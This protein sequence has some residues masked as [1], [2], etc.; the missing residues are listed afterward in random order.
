MVIDVLLLIIG[1]SALIIATITDIKTREVPDWLNFSLIPAGVGL[2]L[3]H[4]LIFNDWMYFFYGII[5]LAVFVGLAYLFYYARQWGG[6]DSKLLMGIGVLFATYPR[7][8]LNYFNP[9]LNWYFLLIFL[10]N[11]LLIGAIYAIIWSSY[12]AV[13]NWEKFKATYKKYFSSL[14]IFRRIILFIAAVLIIASFA[15]AQIEIKIILLGLALVM[16]LSFHLMVFAKVVESCCMFKNIPVKK[17]TEG[18]WVVK[19]VKIKGKY[20]CGPKDYGLTKEQISKLR[21]SRIKNVVIK[22]GIPFVP[23][24]LV[25]MIISLVWG[26]FIYLLI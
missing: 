15:N 6:G 12:L 25:A 22:E 18:D 21:K 10:F 16:F 17:L 11:L 19:E 26:N 4:A 9:V 20:I 24:F 8:L 7:F 23:S 2:R 5:G 3:I 14:R 13:K 1:F